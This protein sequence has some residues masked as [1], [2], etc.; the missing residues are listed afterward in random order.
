MPN[1]TKTAA[2]IATLGLSGW[3]NTIFDAQTGMLNVFPHL[4]SSTEKRLWPATLLGKPISV[5]G[6][7]LSWYDYVRF[8]PSLSLL[9][10]AWLLQRPSLVQ[11]SF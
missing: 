10:Q 11:P 5:T 7:S 4:A 2:Y 9:Q 6:S 3:S 8:R 1:G